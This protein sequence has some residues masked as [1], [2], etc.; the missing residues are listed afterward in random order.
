MKILHVGTDA[1]GGRGGIARYTQDLLRALCSLVGERGS[2]W[3]IPR[4]IVDDPGPLPANLAYLPEAAAGRRAFL[5]ALI[6][7]LGS[8]PGPDVVICGHICLVP[9]AWLAARWARVPL[10]LFGYGIDV[11]EPTSSRLGNFL[12]AR[13]DALV[14][15]TE[16]TAD[17]FCAWLGRDAAKAAIL[18]PCVDLT[19]FTPGPPRQ[20]L[21]AEHGLEGKQVLMTM[22]RL[23]ASERY[24][25]HDEILA[26]LP[27]LLAKRPELVYLIVGDGDDRPRLEQ[28]VEVLG[29]TPH[30]RFAGRID[31]ARK[32]DYYR[33]ADAFAMP[34]RGEGFGIVYLEAM[35]CGIP[36]LASVLDGSREAVKEG[37]LGMMVDPRDPQALRAA[38]DELLSRPKGEPP[39]GL[40][41]F[42]Y[43]AFEKRTHEII[44]TEIPRP[45]ES[46]GV[47]TKKRPI[48]RE[49][50]P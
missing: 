20:D 15:I 43:S 46:G 29:L 34:G 41:W 19:A 42:G 17:R 47:H 12:A 7:A 11:W 36:V 48:N 16:V 22:S 33:I 30:V 14:C 45:G 5:R 31:E 24:K 4:R 10:V 50:L 37:D 2:V 49:H 38:L 3:A 44:R 28:K 26:V 35:A 21:L 13:A 23:D 32:A 1:F 40:D 18:P 8:R 25:G 27:E 6:K 9:Y 39:Q